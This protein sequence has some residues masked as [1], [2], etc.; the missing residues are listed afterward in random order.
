MPV[1]FVL[2]CMRAIGILI[3]LAVCGSGLLGAPFRLQSG[4]ESP[5]LVE[6]YTS[7]GCSS[8]P[9]AEKWLSGFLDD[10]DLWRKFVPVAFH[11]D[12]WD[13]LGWK[14]P[15]ARRENTLRQYRLRDQGALKSIYTPG[16]VVDGKEWRG[17]FEGE[18]LDAG[19]LR[20]SVGVLRVEIDAGQ[21]RV[22][23]TN[24]HDKT[25]VNV[26]ILGIGLDSK[27]T[28]GEN[29]G[30]LL[31]HNFVALQ[32]QEHPLREGK[33]EFALQPIGGGV[34]LKYGIAVWIVSAGEA[35]PNAVVGN[36]LPREAL[37]QI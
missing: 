25:W 32:H 19:G 17:W 22:E 2:Y 28:R 9:P 33:A 10:P 31:E 35:K 21:F 15:F 27:V 24:T 5:R 20:E 14:D 7:E 8:C 6:L 30:R 18:R 29:R 23:F 37:S 26:A 4:S 16:F 11:V 3:G 13:R 1:P 34:P 36:W 12:Y